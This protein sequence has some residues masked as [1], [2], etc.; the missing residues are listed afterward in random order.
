[1]S[2]SGVLNFSLGL[3]AGGFL[4]VLE[5]AQGKV[6]G[7]SK[8]MLSMPGL[9]TAVGGAVA[10]IS[11]LDS[12]VEGVMSAID[13]GAAFEHLSKRTSTSVASLYEL[14]KGFK[15]VG[16]SSDDV[17]GMIFKLQKSLGGI[18]DMGEDTTS[19]FSKIGLNLDD[20]KGM[21]APHQ[22]LAIGSALQKLTPES[23][24]FAASA[25]F[26][27]EGAANMMQLANSTD[28]FATALKK[29]QAQ[30]QQMERNAKA[31]EKIH[32]NIEGVKN[33][34][35]G[36]F[37][38][39]AE[40]AAPALLA[41][42]DALSKI[43][44]SGIGKQIGDIISIITEAFSEGKFGE[45]I[46]KALAAGFS[47]INSPALLQLMMGMAEKLG[48]Y[49]LEAFEYPLNYLQAG[50]TYTA[51]KAMEEFGKLENVFQKIVNVLAA[52]IE[53]A[54]QKMIE[55]L[56]KI[57]KLNA[58]L[59]ITGFRADSYG[60][61]LGQM[62]K[63]HPQQEG[64]KADSWADILADQKKTG[65]RLGNVGLG[66]I[67]SDANK[68]MAEGWKGI[69]DAA[70]PVLDL[71]KGLLKNA[72]KVGAENKPEQPKRE[73]DF[74]NIK[75]HYKPEFTNF[76]K[77]GFIMGGQNDVQQRQLT[78]L[79]EINAGIRKMS[80]IAKTGTPQFDQVVNHV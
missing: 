10:S 63:A 73:V 3:T 20:L 24:A 67:N 13:R 42:T 32:K 62:D 45:L 39:I 54:L 36:L 19:V 58:A 66:D 34:T 12:V 56:A 49:I 4:G 51:E 35:N 8:A 31:F 43:D 74:K 16:L 76:E 22:F 29:S 38:G 40:G 70:K 79:Q 64:F 68:N 11:S 21:D 7:L 44:L 37:V 57:P 26:G 78:V 15:A 23:A 53:Y 2:N 30:A 9:G 25:I 5:K 18:N 65:L 75:N 46:W 50:M 14:Q 69:M 71:S 61:I 55:G 6:T 59:G 80:G 47:I 33:I 41:M 1:M 17:G 52:G 27:R 28:D 77:M 48:Y 72:G 60:E